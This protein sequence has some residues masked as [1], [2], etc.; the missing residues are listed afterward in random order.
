MSRVWENTLQPG[1][2]WSGTIAKGSY[3][4]FTALGE[5]AN[6]SV[7]LYNATNL[8]ERY[9]APD[10]LKAQHTSKLTKGN[11]LMSDNGRVLAS[12]VEDSLGWHDPIGGYSTRELTD[13]KYGKT[14]FQE[15]QNDWLRSGQ[16]NFIVELVRNGLGIRD[17]VPNVN[18]F[19]KIYVSPEGEMH[20]SPSHC[21]K[22]DTVTLRADMDILFLLSNTPNPHDPSVTY[23]SVP[24]K[25]E[26]TKGNEA[27]E[28][29]YCVNYRPEN[30]RA[31]ENTWNYQLLI[32][33]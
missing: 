12:I 26:V 2:K 32:G 25:M 9:N 17:M 15:M 27:D 5:G 24:I 3:I 7:L 28:F 23:P 4:T 21:R 11:V 16:E 13:E 19:S 31:F 30:R 22:G 29:D 10:S 8:S 14:S 6:L 18:L 1:A 33:Q 20:F